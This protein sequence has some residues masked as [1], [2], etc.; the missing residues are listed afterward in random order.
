MRNRPIV[1]CA[2]LLA[3]AI[4]LPRAASAQPASGRGFMFGPPSGTLTLRGGY[5]QPTAGSEVFAFSNK[6][7]TLGRGDYAGGSLSADLGFFVSERLAVQLGAGYSS[8][9][10]DSH[11]RDWVDTQGLEIAQTTTL[12]RVP[13]NIGLRYYLMSPGRS[14]GRLAWIPA[15]VT[16][17]VAGGVGGMLYTFR[18]SGSFVDYQTLDVFPATLASSAWT[19]A[20]YGAVGVDYSLSPKV[21]LAGEVRYDRAHATMGPDFSGFDRI[22]LSGPSA[23]VGLTFRF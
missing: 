21:G 22:D 16:P 2:V 7:L 6:R 23:T 14:I 19:G 9:A 11:F 5:V 4:G 10:A 17:Y 15:R 8:R 18:Q 12:R 20:G 13:L 1:V 3:S